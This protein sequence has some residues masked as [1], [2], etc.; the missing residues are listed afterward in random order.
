M[1]GF[2]TFIGKTLESSLALSATW[3]HNKK[4][5]I[6]EPEMVSCSWISPELTE[7]NVC[8]LSHPLYDIFVTASQTD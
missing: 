7:I 5:N 4:T 1:N 6:Y 8:C 2:S 3:G